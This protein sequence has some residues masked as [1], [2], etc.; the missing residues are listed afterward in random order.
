MKKL[1]VIG[2]FICFLSFIGC[3]KANIM[4]DE[5]VKTTHVTDE[6]IYVYD[7]ITRDDGVQVN[8][9]T[10]TLKCTSREVRDENSDN[11]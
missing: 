2:S 7:T 9:D 5:T 10:A 4:M 11:E 8:S 1:L 6:C 3:D